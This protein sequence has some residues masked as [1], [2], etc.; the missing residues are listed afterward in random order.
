MVDPNFDNTN[1]QLMA[2]GGGG[3]SMPFTIAGQG[4]DRLLLVWVSSRGSAGNIAPT[5]L[6]YDGQTPTGSFPSAATDRFGNFGGMSCF[7]WLESDLPANGSP[8]SHD[9]TGN[10]GSDAF[11]GHLIAT[12][13]TLCEQAPPASGQSS[14]NSNQTSSTVPVTTTSDD[15]L[16][17]DSVAVWHSGSLAVINPGSGQTKRI[18][19]TTTS[20]DRMAVGDAIVGSAALFNR[21][22]NWSGNSNWYVSLGVAINPVGGP[23]VPG[24]QPDSSE[25]GTATGGSALLSVS[26]TIA[27]QGNNRL[28]LAE[29]HGV[30]FNQSN[31][32]ATNVSYDGTPPTGQLTPD[33]EVTEAG[34]AM[35]SSVYYWLEADL[36]ANGSPAAHNLNATSQGS[37]LDLAVVCVS[38][39]DCR[40]QTPVDV[41]RNSDLV[42]GG[43]STVGLTTTVDNSMVVDFLALWSQAFVALATPTAG[44][45]KVQDQ[46]FGPANLTSGA[47]ELVATAGALN[48]TWSWTTT[49]ELYMAFAVALAPLAVVAGDPVIELGNLA[50]G[51]AGTPFNHTLTAANNRGVV[52]MLDCENTNFASSVTYNGANATLVESAQSVVGAGNTSEIWVYFPPDALAAGVYTVSVTHTNTSRVGVRVVELNNIA[53]VVP[54]GTLI[55]NDDQGAAS[56]LTTVTTAPAGPYIAIGIAGHGEDATSF[57]PTPGGT[58]TWNRFFD[59]INPPTSAHF[60]GVH[61]IFSGGEGAITY[62]ETVSSPWNRASMCQALF[63]AVP[64]SGNNSFFRSDF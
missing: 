35:A 43:T 63:A 36:P 29:Y 59:D 39:T 5:N 20:S 13:Y 50:N 51:I 53:Q 19:E 8:T 7:Y 11:G 33:I 44:Q 23:A 30:G 42:D 40:Q 12:S 17:V 14:S 15:A 48:P 31:T 9:V 28:L 22:W 3:F 54:T 52:I 21:V 18:E 27:A 16:I 25:S 56:S 26:L 37:A 47:Y 62:T 57:D 4:Q 32:K 6:Q 49:S 58:G 41:G 24:P 1:S 38:Q 2:G 55:D 46:P 60:V 61:Q 10:S 45:T 34:I 64:T